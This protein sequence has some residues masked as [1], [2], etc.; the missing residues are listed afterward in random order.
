MDQRSGKRGC[1]GE[2]G[3]F[4]LPAEMRLISRT[5]DFALPW[6]DGQHDH[7]VR[8]EPSVKVAGSD[9][10]LIGVSDFVAGIFRCLETLHQVRRLSITLLPL[11][12]R[13]HN[14]KCAQI[15]QAPRRI[16]PQ[17]PPRL[18]GL[19]A[20]EVS[21]AEY[22]CCP[23]CTKIII[24]I[25][26][27]YISQCRDV[28][29]GVTPNLFRRSTSTSPIN[30]ETLYV[31]TDRT[32]RGKRALFDALRLST[33]SPNVRELVLHSTQHF[34]DLRCEAGGVE[35]EHVDTTWSFVRDRRKMQAD[36]QDRLLDS[37]RMWRSVEELDIR[38]R[39]HVPDDL[40]VWRSYLN[41]P[42]DGAR[43]PNNHVIR[44]GDIPWHR[45]GRAAE[46]ETCLERAILHYAASLSGANDKVAGHHVV[47]QDQL[48]VLRQL[49]EALP[50]LSR[51]WLWAKLPH[52]KG[53][54]CRMRYHSCWQHSQASFRFSWSIGH[55][56][57]GT[58]VFKRE[59]I[60]DG[61][62]P[63]SGQQRFIQP[64]GGVQR[65]DPTGAT[66]HTSA[67]TAC[68]SGDGQG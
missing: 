58:R 56:R 20:L 45:C 63:T 1:S 40:A 17:C 53:E 23:M 55:S 13:Q 10:D 51:V 50:N 11:A 24:D 43:W 68:A 34:I 15:R 46:D 7:A 62:Y 64:S 38:L 48:R 12:C 33:I 31:R 18:E 2:V 26:Q 6:P 5:V 42:V 3:V 67:S 54:K 65:P 27:H 60:L 61:P 57:D 19:I 8:G 39:V 28:K 9:F 59:S 66:V 44:S 49:A 37:L 21:S 36:R 47:M 16:S 35:I 52:L 29:L 25:F 41:G 32:N 22:E 14:G 30:A 4:C